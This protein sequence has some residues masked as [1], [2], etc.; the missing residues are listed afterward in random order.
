MKRYTCCLS[1]WNWLDKNL[2]HKCHPVLASQ[3]FRIE[4]L[5]C[6]FP[7]A[8]NMLWILSE[9]NSDLAYWR[10]PMW[11]N[12]QTG[13]DINSGTLCHLIFIWCNTDLFP[14][15]P[16]HKRNLF[17]HRGKSWRP[18]L[19]VGMA[20]S[21]VKM[22]L[23]RFN[24]S[25]PLSLNWD[26]THLVLDYIGLFSFF[27][28]FS[29]FLIQFL[30]SWSKDRCSVFRTYILLVSNFLW[31]EG[32]SLLLKVK[33]KTYCASLSLFGPHTQSLN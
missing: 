14:Y 30:P 31:K 21:G 1:K 25:L 32:E 28:S 29:F 4:S 33:Q 27:L 13:W 5:R 12:K 3:T 23:T 6:Y 2:V 24:S 19:P 9:I 20:W 16:E 18:D 26:L 15:W 22:I 11:E 7:R 10:Y 8:L 17:T